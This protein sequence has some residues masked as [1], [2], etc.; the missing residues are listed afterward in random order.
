MQGDSGDFE[1]HADRLR[2][3]K[4]LKNATIWLPFRDKDQLIEFDSC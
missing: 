3:F 1:N 4:Y 2:P